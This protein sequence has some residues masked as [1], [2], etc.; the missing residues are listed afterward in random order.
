MTHKN[1]KK[2]LTSEQH[3]EDGEDLLHVGVGRH[4]AEADGRERGEREVERR[5]VLGAD[6]GSA[7][8]VVREVR[9][10][11]LVT[12]V[13]EPRD[14]LLEPRPLQV[15]DR[16]EDTCRKVESSST[17]LPNVA[18][19]SPHPRD[20]QTS[21]I[22]A[23][24]HFVSGSDTLRRPEVHTATES[25]EVLTG[26]RKYSQASQCATSVNDAMRRMSTA[27]PYSEY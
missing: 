23:L 10:V 3:G 14:L 11:D 8:R 1:Q 7:G 13:V 9:T 22:I 25:P 2:T 26:D 27:A 5:D 12:Q 15:R 16:V 4:V 6:V 17:M 21:E 18:S 20:G 24:C 19:T